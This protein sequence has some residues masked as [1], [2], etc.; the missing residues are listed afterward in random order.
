MLI[1]RLLYFTIFLHNSK[2]K[3]TC[4][5]L[6]AARNAPSW[7]RLR[8][9]RDHVAFEARVEIGDHFSQIY[10]SCMSVKEN[11]KN[12]SEE[13]R[14]RTWDASHFESEAK[15]FG[16]RKNMPHSPILCSLSDL[17]SPSFSI[18]CLMRTELICSLLYTVVLLGVTQTTLLSGPVQPLAVVIVYIAVFALLVKWYLIIIIKHKLSFAKI[19]L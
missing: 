8:Q 5:P 3:C 13:M 2:A 17:Q 16:E 4:C 6:Q 15:N 14:N 18:V 11:S 12:K 1:Q 10:Y 9:T 19:Y 7:V